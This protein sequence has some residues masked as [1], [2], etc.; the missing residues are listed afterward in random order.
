MKRF[1]RHGR[2]LVHVVDTGRKVACSSTGRCERVIAS[3]AQKL[4][5][6]TAIELW[7]DDWA[8]D[9]PELWNTFVVRGGH[10][11]PVASVRPNPT[12]PLGAAFGRPRRGS[13]LE[14]SD[15]SRHWVVSASKGKQRVVEEE[16]D[17]TFTVMDLHDHVEDGEWLGYDVAVVGTASSPR[18]AVTVAKRRKAS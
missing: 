6:G 2:Y 15:A 9:E 17:G 11:R 18:Q 8:I 5:D 12:G 4:P 14:E 16:L 10:P 1:F 7:Y 13:L 3:E